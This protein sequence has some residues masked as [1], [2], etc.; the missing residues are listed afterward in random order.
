MNSSRSDKI[1]HWCTETFVHGF[2]VLFAATG[3]VKVMGLLAD[4]MEIAAKTDA[5]LPF[6]SLRTTS[7]AAAELEILCASICLFTSSHQ[8][9][10][11][12][13]LWMST[14]FGSYRLALWLHGVGT[15]PCLGNLLAGNSKLSHSFNSV[16]FWSVCLGILG[17][18]TLLADATLRR[19]LRKG[20]NTE[21]LAEQHGAARRKLPAF[22]AG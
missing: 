20:Q 8:F 7:W 13:V 21:G 6:L 22:R 15:C 19:R 14:L 18:A 11:W 1:R 12:A 5:V 17:S 4:G 16:L 2:A 10:L 3:A 9:R